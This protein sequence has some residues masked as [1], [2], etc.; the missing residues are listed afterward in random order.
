[1]T[2]TPITSCLANDDHLWADRPEEEQEEEFDAAAYGN[3]DQY[4]L[5]PDELDQDDDRFT[6]SYPP[7]VAAYFAAAGINQL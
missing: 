3:G 7:T 1:M 4:E 6:D 2:T 5:G